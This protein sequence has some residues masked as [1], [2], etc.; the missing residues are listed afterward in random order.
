MYRLISVLTI[1]AFVF[2]LASS[3]ETETPKLKLSRSERTHVD[4]IYRQ[5]IP[6]I[7]KEMDSIC[8]A[9]RSR[10]YQKKKDSIIAIRLSEIE[11]ILPE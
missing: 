5:A 3:C 8:V 2:I 9:Y 10:Q 1:T 7:N 6:A 4:S 11:Q